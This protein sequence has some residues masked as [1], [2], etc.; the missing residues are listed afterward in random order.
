MAIFVFDHHQCYYYYLITEA[1]KY[2]LKYLVHCGQLN[3]PDS[4]WSDF[5]ERILCVDPILEG[6]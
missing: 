6:D 5:R 1:A 2:A 3:G 4:D